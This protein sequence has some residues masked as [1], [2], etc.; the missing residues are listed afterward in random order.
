MNKI[1]ANIK[2]QLKNSFSRDIFKFILFIHPLIHS[3][4]MYMLYKNIEIK[5]YIE[6]A[7][8]GTGLLS[9]WSVILFSSASDI[10]RERN[11]GTLSTIFISPTNFFLLIFSKLIGNTILGFLPILI[12][13]TFL[14]M[15]RPVSLSFNFLY[16]LLNLICGIIVLTLLSTIFSFLFAISKNTRLLMNNLEY[17]LYIISGLVFPIEILPSFL[18]KIAALF[19]LYWIN[20]NFRNILCSNFEIEDIFIL[21]I[22]FIVYL[23]LIKL[24]YINFMNKIKTKG[25]IEV[26]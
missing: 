22:F 7:L 14:F 19:P 13:S 15:L 3:F 26:M 17:P 23:C 24:L 10:E 12:S 16:F 25:S 4:I 11:E 20:E 5:F 6:Y 1:L 9:F 8:L 21:I 2:I 18:Q